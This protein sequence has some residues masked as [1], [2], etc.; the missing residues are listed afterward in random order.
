MSPSA[1]RLQPEPTLSPEAG[2]EGRSDGP[3]PRQ[4][5]IWSGKGKGLHRLLAALR[6]AFPSSLKTSNLSR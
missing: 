2:N 3:I 1:T 5:S 6:A 4:D